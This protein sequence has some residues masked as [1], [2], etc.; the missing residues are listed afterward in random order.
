MLF[1]LL[2]LATM[3]TAA[4]P[5]PLQAASLVFVVAALV[6]GI[7]ALGSVWRAGVRGALVPMLAIGLAFTALLS[8]A[9]AGLLA[10]WPMQLDRQHCLQDALTIS[11]NAKCQTDYEHTLLD[12]RHSLEDRLRAPSKARAAA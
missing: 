11:A 2:L 1:G 4:L 7:R 3:A 5:L 8:V 12:Y 9:T 6:V 10:L